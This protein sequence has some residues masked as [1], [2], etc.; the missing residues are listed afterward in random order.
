MNLKP[1]S[2]S[3]FDFNLFLM[4]KR[5][6]FVGMIL[7]PV[8][9][10]AQREVFEKK[11]FHRAGHTLL[12]RILYPKGYN[13]S[14]AYPVF[15]FLHGSGERG[16]DNEAQLT[17]GGDLF[18]NDSVRNT[19]PAI[20]IFPQL[21]KDSAWRHITSTVDTSSITGQKVNFSLSSRPTT[22]AL[23]VKLL[24][25]SL[26]SSK[27]G[28]S[29]RMYIGGLSL[30]GFGTF[31]MIERYPGFFAAAVPMCGGGDVNLAKRFA[32]KTALWIFHGDKDPA[33]DVKYSRQY[34]DAL[35]KL[36][37]DVRY[38]EYPG[39][40]HNSWDYAFKEKQLLPWVLSKAKR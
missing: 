34:Y 31:D 9:L 33:V 19:F 1:N 17:H 30:G 16:D 23:L 35:K 12:Y 4:I 40:G 32:K 36:G 26:V 25:D 3:L 22:P 24:L 10:F 11:T 5:W 21:P 18:A 14:R 2:I 29:R 39:V 15:T 8:A 7:I 6:L 13:H 20:V 37:A 27:V 38:T 28:D